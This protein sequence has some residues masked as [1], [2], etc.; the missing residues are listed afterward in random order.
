MKIRY[1]SKVDAIYIE[2]AKGAYE[3]SRVVSDAVV[4]DEDKNGNV[5]GIEILDAK[6]HI[7][8]FDP[9]NTS[10]SVKSS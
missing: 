1:D 6:K 2:F 3:V 8:A 7:A 9:H 5:L 4:V 10:I